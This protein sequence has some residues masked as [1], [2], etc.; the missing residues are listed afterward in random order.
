MREDIL[1]REIEI[2]RWIEENKPKA[3]MCKEFKCKPSTLET[4][5]KRLGIQYKGN[6]GSKGRPSRKR[7][8]AI[9]YLNDETFISSHKLKNRLIEDNIFERKCHN[10]KLTKWLGKPIPIELHHKDGNRFNNRKKNL[11]I[12]CP[13]CHSM[14]SN[15]SGKANVRMV[16]RQ[17][18]MP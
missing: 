3:F 6:M 8:P 15:N 16:E 1:N 2:R 18:R 4:Y 12:L 13:N 14:T 17:T 7:K 5:L 11:Q 10:C 9:E